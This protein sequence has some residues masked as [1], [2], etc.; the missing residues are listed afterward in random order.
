MGFDRR[1]AVSAGDR[2]AVVAVLNEVQLSDAIG[3]DGG[4]RLAAPACRGDPLPSAL[5]SAS[6]RSK[7]SVELAAPAIDGTDDRVDGDRL[8][9]EVAFGNP[10]QGGH[11]ISERQQRQC[12]FTFRRQARS[13]VREGSATMFAR[14]CCGGIGL[15]KSGEHVRNVLTRSRVRTYGCARELANEFRKGAVGEALPASL[16]PAFPTQRTRRDG[17]HWSRDPIGSCGRRRSRVPR[18]GHA[19]VRFQSLGD[20][21]INEEAR[22]AA[23]GVGVEQALRVDHRNASYQRARQAWS[24]RVAKAD[25]RGKQVPTPAR[26]GTPYERLSVGELTLDTARVAARSSRCSPT[27]FSL[28][29]RGAIAPPTNRSATSPS[30]HPVALSSC[31]VGPSTASWNEYGGTACPTSPSGT[32]DRHLGR[33]RMYT[34]ERG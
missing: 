21:T 27:R 20:I 30:T 14:K 6:A 8:E 5:E 34:H 26:R 33:T 22:G 13:D 15:W 1:V 3:V 7:Y 31:A 17:H 10:S 25:R 29:L 11:Y 18:A 28:R 19:T 4:H 24:D 2:N 16:F 32:R 23:A 12:V 9:P